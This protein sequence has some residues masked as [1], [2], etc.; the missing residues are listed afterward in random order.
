MSRSWVHKVRSNYGEW[1]DLIRS[2]R[3]TTTANDTTSERP[4]DIL[5]GGANVARLDPN[6][7]GSDGVRIRCCAFWTIFARNR[8]HSGGYFDSLLR[9]LA[10]D[11]NRAGSGGRDRER[12]IDGAV[13][14]DHPRSERRSRSNKPAFRT[15]CGCGGT[16]LRR[17]GGNGSLY[18]SHAVTRAVT[19]FRSS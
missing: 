11:R 18:I 2:V 5:C 12:S 7:T 4:T 13:S 10:L 6:R 15:R 3:V 9:I 16:P 14:P 17:R 19:A 1:D 8:I